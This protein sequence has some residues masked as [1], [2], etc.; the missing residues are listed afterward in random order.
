MN[1]RHSIKIIK[2]G[3]HETSVIPRQVRPIT[4]TKKWV[5]AVQSWISQFQKRRSKS[6]P[7][8]DSIFK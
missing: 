2:N 4:D 1:K 7:P 3:K 8:F 6:L 5:T